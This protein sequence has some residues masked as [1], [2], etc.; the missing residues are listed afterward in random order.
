MRFNLDEFIEACTLHYNPEGARR[1][2]VSLSSHV[3]EFDSGILYSIYYHIKDSIS[4]WDIG[5]LEHH[6]SG[7]IVLYGFKKDFYLGSKP[8]PL[9]PV[10]IF[11]PHEDDPQVVSDGID[12]LV[13]RHKNRV[14]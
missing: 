1:H 10:A 3:K 13:L 2:W 14:M 12:E 7:M 9:N 4:C 11:N 6:D 5:R 8:D